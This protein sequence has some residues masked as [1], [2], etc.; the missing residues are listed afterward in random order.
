MTGPFEFRSFS[1]THPGAKRRL[2]ED[3][4]VDRPEAGIWAVADGVGGSE[5][6]DVA[7]T[8]ISAALMAVPA[9][10]SGEQMLAE[11]RRCLQGVHGELRAMAAA[12]LP[13]ATIASTAVVLIAAGAY[14]AC[15][16]VGDS[17]I[18]LLRGGKLQQLTRDHSLV[19]EMVDAGHI[20][21]AEAD[22]HPRANV[23]TRAIGA[24]DTGLEIDKVTGALL[25]GD[26]FLLCSDG[27]TKAL[28]EVELVALL[29]AP[30][31]APLT[32]LLIQA[33]LAHEASDNVTAVTVEV[34]EGP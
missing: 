7:S 4:Y 11:L 6:G 17:R 8:A 13:P 23:I 31:G 28:N 9:G 26:R 5:A 15:L 33:A 16:W 19:Q 30:E 1:L 25:P 32:D 24:G 14:F 3:S 34:R 27:L 2:N 12:R 22:H 21:A 20:P 18:Y 10:L 29:G